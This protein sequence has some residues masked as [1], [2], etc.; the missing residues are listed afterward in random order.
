MT[1]FTTRLRRTSRT[2]LLFGALTAGC[3]TESS[4]QESIARAVRATRDGTIRMQFRARAGVCGSGRSM[5]FSTRG[6]HAANADAEWSGECEP[7]PVRVAM[8]IINGSPV[9]I[10]FYV[11]GR[12][13]ASSIATDV[14]TVAA[15]D[16]GP[17]FAH[18][19]ESAPTRVAREAISVATIADSSE[20]WPVLLRIARSTSVAR[21]VRSSAVFWLGQTASDVAA[22]LNGLV[23]DENEDIEIRKQAVFALSQRPKDES[24]PALLSIARGRLDPRIRRSA[25]FWLGQSGDPR[26]L[27]YFESV[28]ARP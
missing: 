5:S 17:Y 13:Q 2:A 28:L 10:R 11:G 21:D 8:D 15:A 14:G 12:W 19:A 4:G 3:A 26:A 27:A 23:D 7:G 1:T 20:V 6:S 22:A 9:A 24:V 16:A 18:L 25:I